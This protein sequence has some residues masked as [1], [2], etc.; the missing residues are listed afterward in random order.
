MATNK[1]QQFT[2]IVGADAARYNMRLV[3]L[4]PFLAFGT[5]FLGIPCYIWA[6]LSHT[7]YAWI[8]FGAGVAAILYTFGYLGWL[9]RRIHTLS[10]AFF[11][12]KYG[13][14]MSVGA[15]FLPEGMT[16][17]VSRAK[18]KATGNQSGPTSASS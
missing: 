3:R 5:L 14:E 18:E 11:A 1:Q 7:T 17:A 13:L 10:R 15:N 2:G 16:K 4:F 9:Q 6:L 12:E 8:V